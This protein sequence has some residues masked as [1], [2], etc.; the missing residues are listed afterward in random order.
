MKALKPR[1]IYGHNKEGKYTLS[2]FTNT[3]KTERGCPLNRLLVKSKERC[4]LAAPDPAGNKN[5]EEENDSRDRSRNKS[6]AE[7]TACSKTAE[8]RRRR[9]EQEIINP[10]AGPE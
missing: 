8:Q 4:P 6:I 3:T 5:G 10:A 9:P 7:K 2:V 1:L